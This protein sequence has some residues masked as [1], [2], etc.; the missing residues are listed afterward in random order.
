MRFGTLIGL[1][2]DSSK[3]KKI[4]GEIDE[5]KVISA[6]ELLSE[7]KKNPQIYCP[8]MIIAL[9]LL[10]NSEN[11]MF[12]KYEKILKP[13]LGKEMHEVFQKAI[14]IHLPDDNWRVVK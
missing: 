14:K 2:E 10:D 11:Q 3:C 6:K 1:V 8:W 13:W 4:E 9:E 12:K 5:V 7:L